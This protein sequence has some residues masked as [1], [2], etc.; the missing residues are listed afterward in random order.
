MTWRDYAKTL[1]ALVVAAAGAL[2]TALGPGDM[3]LGDLSTKSW[4]E[5]IIAVLGSAVFVHA[6]DNIPGG[7][8]Q[9]AKALAAAATAG[10]GA[11][12]LAIADESA[13]GANVT[14]SEWLG[15]FITAVLATGFVY[16]TTESNSPKRLRFTIPG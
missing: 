9:V 13:A 5:A 11:F 2:V 8:G 7:V 6:L 12:L 1:V 16:Q 4:V 15:V 3:S 10:L 14:Q